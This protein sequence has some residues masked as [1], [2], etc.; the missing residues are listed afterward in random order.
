[1]PKP[2]DPP[3]SSGMSTPTEF[4]DRNGRAFSY[5]CWDEADV[6]L[7]AGAP[8]FAPRQ[9]HFDHAD[10][11][12][13][14][15]LMRGATI[16]GQLTRDGRPLANAPVSLLRARSPQTLSVL[17]GQ[18]TSDEQGRY[19]FQRLTP[20]LPYWIFTPL[21]AAGRFGSVRAESTRAGKDGSATVAPELRANFGHTLAGRIVM[22]PGTSLAGR[23]LRL[24]LVRMIGYEESWS[25]EGADAVQT[26]VDTTGA[27]EFHGVPEERVRIAPE[28]N[29]FK[30]ADRLEA[31]LEYWTFDGSALITVRADLRDLKLPMAI[32]P[33]E[34]GDR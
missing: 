6:M 9:L 3:N 2:T 32:V 30:L 8:G 17:D 27:F 24:R 23:R 10:S 15:S 29:G 16:R 22:P 18:A 21:A 5:R 1:M 34:I 31:P 12:Y 28:L 26:T 20:E 13:E 4:A 33:P 7:E 11:L 25:V 19:E 14:I